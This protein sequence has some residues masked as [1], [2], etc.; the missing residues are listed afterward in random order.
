MK[1][2]IVTGAN[3]AIGSAIAEGIA[4]TPGYRVVL[5][6]RDEDKARR[7]S[8]AVQRASGSRDVHY[9]IADLSRPQQV[10][11]LGSRWAEPLDVL[12]NNAA[13][14]PRHKQTT[15]EGLELQ[16]ATNV[17]SYVWMMEAFRDALRRAAPSR[18][19]NVASYWAGDL[20]LSDLQFQR[21]RY[22]NDQAYRQSKQ[23]N[24]MLTVAYAKR[25]ADDGITVNA[26]HPGDVRSQLSR[27]LGFGGHESPE[28]GARTPVWLATQLVGGEVTGRYFADMQEAECRFGRNASAVEALYEA[29]H[30]LQVS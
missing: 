21:R 1:T 15:P 20:D 13:V 30:R 14:A 19:V 4:A 12:V 8:A 16:L 17:M 5:V 29:V 18:I 26:C 25:F 9:E 23:A 3:G 28:Q 24:R 7:T 6:C 11:A 27:D 2:A 10:A 22:D